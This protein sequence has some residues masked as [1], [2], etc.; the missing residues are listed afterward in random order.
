MGDGVHRST[1]HW[2][3]RALGGCGDKCA[4]GS[5]APACRHP[6]IGQT[7]PD[8]SFATDFHEYAVEYSADHINFA[9]DGVVFQH[10]DRSSESHS[11]GEKAEYFDVPYYM[12]LNTAVG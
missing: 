9:L 7:Y 1:Y 6:Q 5:T 11:L 3:T 10:L 2:R 8:Q 12:I 4:N